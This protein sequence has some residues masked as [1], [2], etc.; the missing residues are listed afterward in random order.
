MNKN[1]KQNY[2]LTLYFLYNLPKKYSKYILK[3]IFATNSFFES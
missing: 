2:V 1:S 3:I